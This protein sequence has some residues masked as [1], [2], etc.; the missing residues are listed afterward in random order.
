MVDAS[1]PTLSQKLGI[2]SQSTV[3]LVHAPRGFLLPLVDARQLREDPSDPVDVV[4]A[5]FHSEHELTSEIA[6]L[7]RLVGPRGALWIAWP[8]KSSGAISDLNDQVVRDIGLALGLVDNKVCAIDHTFSALRFVSRRKE[9]ARSRAT[10]PAQNSR[11][12]AGRRGASTHDD[13]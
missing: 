6:T 10:A 9:S 5:F 3:T 12:R 13:S 7:D 1:S 4:L 2:T 8:K 11:T